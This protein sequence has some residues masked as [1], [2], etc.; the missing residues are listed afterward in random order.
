LE[1]LVFY[2]LEVLL[3]AVA[4]AVAAAGAM[5]T[6]ADVVVPAEAVDPECKLQVPKA[7]EVCDPHGDHPTY[8]GDILTE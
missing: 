5:A 8:K 4:A 2:L 7:Q 1:N 3:A 6:A